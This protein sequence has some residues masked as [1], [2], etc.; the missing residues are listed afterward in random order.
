M[1]FISCAVLEGAREGRSVAELM[2]YGRTLLT[3]E[4]MGPLDTEHDA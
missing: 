1:A 3:R 4:V 2:D